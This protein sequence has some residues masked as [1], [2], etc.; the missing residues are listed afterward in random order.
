MAQCPHRAPPVLC[1]A[2][3]AQL[4]EIIR[5]IGREVRQAAEVAEVARAA[6]PPEGPDAEGAARAMRLEMDQWVALGR[7]LQRIEEV[8][9]A[10]R[11]AQ[12]VEQAASESAPSEAALA[13]IVPAVARLEEAL[14]SLSAELTVRKLT[15]SRFGGEELRV[16][17][18]RGPCGC[19]CDGA[20][21][22]CSCV[23]AGGEE[24]GE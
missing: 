10:V 20:I 16:P 7:R 5:S 17:R 13:G 18:S 9:A 8:M 24:G 15:R 21:V 11:Q 19:G 4:E 6:A 22:P 3:D 2:A 12:A 14:S 23:G 1:L